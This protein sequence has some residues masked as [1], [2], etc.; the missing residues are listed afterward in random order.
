MLN[1]IV[2]VGASAA[3]LTAV[4]TLRAKGYGGELTLVGDERHPPYERPPLS[5]ELL[6]EGW[7]PPSTWLRKEEVLAAVDAELRLGC[8]ATG[9]DPAARTVALSTGERLPYDAAIIATGLRPRRLPCGDGL[10][11]V[12][13]LRSLDDAVRLREALAAGPRVAVIGAGFLG[14]EIAATAR[15]AGLD[16]TLIDTNAQPLARQVGAEIGGLV[17][18]LHRDHGV[19]LV[20]GADV[21]G[22]ARDDAGVRGVLLA[23]GTTVDAELVVVA[24]GS[25][26]AVDW[27]AESGLPLGDGVLCDAYCRAAPGVW[28]AGDVANW[29][30][31]VVAGARV[32]LEQRTNAAQQAMAVAANLLAGEAGA[33]PYAPVPFGWTHQFG[34][35]IQTIGWC[36]PDARTEIISGSTAD[37]EFVAAYHRDGVLVGGLGWNSARGLRQCRQLLGRPSSELAAT[38]AGV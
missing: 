29:P 25:V 27:L 5:K 22:M 30:H 19:R 2:V 15:G 37:R 13:V 32:R 7:E 18:G 17:A 10:R 16:V 34:E 14:A 1:R 33:K 3:G 9:L 23:D 20:L 11:G 36:P 38:A 4:E 28:A 6:S 31:P 12:H 35:K 26:P 21:V 8:R 24:I